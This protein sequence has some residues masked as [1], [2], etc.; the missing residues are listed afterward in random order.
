MKRILLR[1]MALLLTLSLLVL[2]AG[3]SDLEAEI[4]QTASGL[5]AFGG[6]P[7]RLLTQEADLPA[8]S[9]ISDWTA[10]ALALSGQ[11]ERFDSYRKR[12]EDRITK[13]Y[14]ENGG[15]DPVEANPYHRAALTVLALGADPTAFG[16][17]ADGSPIDLIAD[18]T[19]A[20]RGESIG[21]QGLNGWIYALLVLDASGV[22]V[23]EDA[24]F[25]R[26]DMID[27]ILAA[28]E[29]DG[30]FGLTEGSS[31]VDITAMALQALAPYQNQYPREIQ[32]A[33]T[34]LSDQMNGSCRFQ[35]Y[36]QE[37][38]ES[39]AQVIL[40]LCSLGIDPAE[41]NQFTIGIENLL[42]GLAGF[43]LADGSYGHLR[44]DTQGNCLA[45]AQCLLALT[46]LSRLREGRRLYDFTDYPGPNAASPSRLL[47]VVS[48]AIVLCLGGCLVLLRKRR[49]YGK[50]N[51]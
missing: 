29:E 30:G 26:Q 40:A 23:P 25:S 8:G 15:L 16:T 33:L 1:W 41:A 18:G 37:S 6:K 28:Q 31:D 38:A 48:G 47:Y 10:I 27:A 39:S 45:T 3:A 22:S 11:E 44:E 19:Y 49:K 50:N 43:R 5:S 12:L 2:P 14:E 24:R 17:K 46:A 7:G 13:R 34:Y 21:A 4:A 36:G 51:G 35:S 9:S 42:T 32:L 20:F